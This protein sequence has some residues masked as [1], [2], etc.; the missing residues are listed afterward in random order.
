MIDKR[1]EETSDGCFEGYPKR[2]GGGKS[3]PVTVQVKKRVSTKKER[4]NENIER[5]C[6]EACDTDIQKKR[7][8]YVLIGTLNRPQSI[9]QRNL[10]I[11]RHSIGGFTPKNRQAVPIDHLGS[12]SGGGD[13]KGG[14]FSKMSGKTNSE[15]ISTTRKKKKK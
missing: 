7:R 1:R 13:R 15:K 11:G 8:E 14:T 12:Y 4:K 9:T 10:V 5:A 3:A 6:E 2:F